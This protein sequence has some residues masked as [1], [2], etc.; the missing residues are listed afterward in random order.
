[1]HCSNGMIIIKGIRIPLPVSHC[2]ATEAFYNSFS[3]KKTKLFET[4]LSITAMQKWWNV[5]PLGCF[6]IYVQN[7]SLRSYTLSVKL[8]LGSPSF[9]VKCC[10]TIKVYMR[11][12]MM[13]T[14]MRFSA[15]C[16]ITLYKKNY[17]KTPCNELYFKH[18]L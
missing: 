15:I 4:T 2:E 8:H 16:L 6:I 10:D 13:D 5:I 7:W 1:M 9:L 11:I 17:P 12:R 3:T 18:L 14:W